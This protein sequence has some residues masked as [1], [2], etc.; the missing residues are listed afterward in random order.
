MAQLPDPA[1]EFIQDIRANTQQMGRLIDDLL[2]FSR[3]NRHSIRKQLLPAHEFVRECFEELIKNRPDQQ[4]NFKIEPLTEF[5]ADRSLLKQVLLNLL[6]NALK[7]TGKKA[8]PE[9]T[10]GEIENEMENVYFIKDNGVGFDM[11]YAHKLFGVFQRLHR[12]EDYE[13]TGVGLA[14][15]QRIINRHSGRVWAEATINDGA[16]FY[17]SLPLEGARSHVTAD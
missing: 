17:F 14:I 15:V 5:Y 7:F 12:Q 9:I 3:L 13:G 6:A 2:A 10:V 4:I 1:R 8:S 16:T 11:R